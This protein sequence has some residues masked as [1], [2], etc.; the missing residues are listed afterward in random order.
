MSSAITVGKRVS[1]P[2]LC[3]TRDASRFSRSWG[4]FYKSVA[5]V[6]Y[7]QNTWSCEKEVCRCFWCFL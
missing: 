6:I 2:I 5:A 1:S 7:G 3:A 4:R